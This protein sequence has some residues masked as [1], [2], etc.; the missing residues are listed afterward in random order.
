MGLVP[1]TRTIGLT[2]KFVIEADE[3]LNR[4]FLETLPGELTIGGADLA[5]IRLGVRG[6]EIEPV[7]VWVQRQNVSI[8]REDE[9]L[10]GS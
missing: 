3:D 7:R 8:E 6:R 10:E 2:V 5:S 4:Q 9:F 1:T